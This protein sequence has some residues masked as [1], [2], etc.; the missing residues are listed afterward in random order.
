MGHPV[1]EEFLRRKMDTHNFHLGLI[2]YHPFYHDL[3]L[4][5]NLGPFPGPVRE[6]LFHHLLA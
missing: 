2:L 3:F 6:D 4:V 1:D 5:L